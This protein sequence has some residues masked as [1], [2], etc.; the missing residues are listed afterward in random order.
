[1]NRILIISQK[2]FKKAQKEAKKHG[3]G[4]DIRGIFSWVEK[5]PFLSDG[6]VLTIHVH[7]DVP[8]FQ[9]KICKAVS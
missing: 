8:E 5:H 6:E 9:V 1:M 4:R 2:E 3:K 7:R